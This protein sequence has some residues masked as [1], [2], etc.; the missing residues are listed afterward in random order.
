M[1]QIIKLYFHHKDRHYSI[2]VR[3]LLSPFLLL[4]TVSTPVSTVVIT[5]GSFCAIHPNLAEVCV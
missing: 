4:P 2:I 5:I 1:L 3:V